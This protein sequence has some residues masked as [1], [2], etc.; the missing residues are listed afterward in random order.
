MLQF[1]L[2]LWTHMKG[3][4]YP[5]KLDLV[6]TKLDLCSKMFQKASN[7]ECLRWSP[8]QHWIPAASPKPTCSTPH[9]QLTPMRHNMW[10]YRGIQ[11]ILENYVFTSF[12][13]KE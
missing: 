8:Q 12:C 5:T 1:S 7:E 3:Q 11:Q 10:S 6:S 4:L 9:P 2:T 13:K